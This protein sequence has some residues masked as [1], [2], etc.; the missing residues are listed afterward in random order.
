M[1]D[2]NLMDQKLH[3]LCQPIAKINRTFVAKEEDDSHTNIGLDIIANRLRGHW[4]KKNNSS[5][6]VCFNIAD[7]C[8]EMLDD[9]FHLIWKLSPAGLRMK[10]VEEG[11]NL[12]LES[13]SINDSN[14]M[15]DL[16]FE[17]PDYDFRSK[18][19]PDLDAKSLQKWLHFRGIASY[20]ALDLNNHFNLESSIRIWPHHFDTGSYLEINN[21]L[22]IGFGLAMK[23]SIINQA[24]FYISAYPQKGEID[25]Y[26]L[27]S[28][29]P[30]EWV[31]EE[32]WKGAVL[33]LEKLS[34]ISEEK[35]LEAIQSYIK[36]A[37]ST[38]LKNY[39]YH[40]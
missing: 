34:K 33:S 29:D 10:E 19:I 24:Y 39:N 8:Y 20:A 25:Y 18:A 31:I 2:Y 30:W 6:L 11:I 4:F 5:Y 17:I 13:H 28:T 16:H 12:K 23:D 37:T 21:S 38:L 32:K 27:S 3:W 40:Q 22:G 36:E 35:Q 14:W 15:K 9:G 7:Q 1:E 26:K